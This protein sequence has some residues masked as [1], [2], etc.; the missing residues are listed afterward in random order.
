M[1]IHS[2]KKL[3]FFDESYPL[4]KLTQMNLEMKK[5]IDMT[6]KSSMFN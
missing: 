1:A 6:E 5:E 4:K 3:Q 2:T